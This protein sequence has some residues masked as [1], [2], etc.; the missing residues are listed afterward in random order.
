MYISLAVHQEHD[1]AV[2]VTR[3]SSSRALLAGNSESASRCWFARSLSPYLFQIYIYDE[4][5]EQMDELEPGDFVLLK[6]MRSIK[7]SNSS[8]DLLFKLP[9]MQIGGSNFGRALLKIASVDANPYELAML[10]SERGIE[11][12]IADIARKGR[13]LG[14]TWFLADEFRSKLF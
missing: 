7:P 12:R 8:A 9:G 1:F 6:N 2:E 5:L 10:K 3:A 14:A 13:E 11:A 4:F